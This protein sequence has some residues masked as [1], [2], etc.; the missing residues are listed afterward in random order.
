MVMHTRPLTSFAHLVI[1]NISPCLANNPDVPLPDFIK[2]LF[3]D[4]DV[5]MTSSSESRKVI[6]VHL[7][8]G[9]AKKT[10]ASLSRYTFLKIDAFTTDTMKSTKLG[11]FLFRTEITLIRFNINK[12]KTH[13]KLFS[14]ERMIGCEK[15][16][17]RF[18]EAI[19]SLRHLPLVLFLKSAYL[20]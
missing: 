1:F 12:V 10:Y 17:V 13:Q 4:V 15:N 14:R 11:T 8:N 16:R 6:S 18:I 9:N 2:T 20:S 3:A 5:A 19:Q 7:R